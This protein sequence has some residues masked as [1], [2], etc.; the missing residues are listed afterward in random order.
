MSGPSKDW[1]RQMKKMLPSLAKGIS[2]KRA[3]GKGRKALMIRKA[4]KVCQYCAKLHDFAFFKDE[5]S[6]ELKIDACQH[7]KDKL[8]A[9]YTAIVSQGGKLC[10]VKSERLKEFAGK[11]IHV[12]PE[13][14]ALIEAEYKANWAPSEPEKKTDEQQQQP[15]EPA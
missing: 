5:V 2:E 3:I 9:G 8:E 7:C 13:N 15:P 10:F 1:L 6:P 4:Q 14:F 11:S 12:S